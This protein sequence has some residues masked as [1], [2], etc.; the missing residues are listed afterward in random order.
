MEQ[1]YAISNL[2]LWAELSIVRKVGN[3]NEK[4]SNL[5]SY[6]YIK[7]VCCGAM[8]SASHYCTTFYL[9]LKSGS[10][11]IQMLLMAC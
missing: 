10:T 11:Q 9:N 7:S 3:Q 4:P 2:E 6:K 5:G 8:S 1:E